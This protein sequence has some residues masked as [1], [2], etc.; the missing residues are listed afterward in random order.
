MFRIDAIAE[1]E[2]FLGELYYNQSRHQS[3]LRGIALE[4]IRKNNTLE[5][6]RASSAEMLT[7]T[8]EYFTHDFAKGLPPRQTQSF[9]DEKGRYTYRNIGGGVESVY[10]REYGKRPFPTTDAD[11]ENLGFDI[12]AKYPGDITLRNEIRLQVAAAKG[13][14][15]AGDPDEARRWLVRKAGELGIS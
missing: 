3:Q 13:D 1:Q 2:R 15:K 10:M 5:Y 9:Q 12:E 7:E 4:I 11:W 6:L 8:D 14:E